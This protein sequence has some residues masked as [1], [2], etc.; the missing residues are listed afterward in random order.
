MGERVGALSLRTLIWRS[1]LETE[2]YWWGWVRAPF[3]VLGTLS[4][5]SN[6][7]YKIVCT[8]VKV[9]EQECADML[10]E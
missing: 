1:T 8:C 6:F 7:I 5:T 3:G 10:H 9:Y 2:C 4:Q